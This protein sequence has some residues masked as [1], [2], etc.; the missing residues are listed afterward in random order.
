MSTPGEVPTCLC[1]RCG[2]CAAETKAPYVAVK[3][4]CLSI[5]EDTLLC[6]LGPNGAGKTTT[7]HML[8]GF[9]ESTSGDATVF[10][11]SVT[12]NISEIQGIMGVCPQ[13]DILVRNAM[14]Q[15]SVQCADESSFV[16][17]SGMN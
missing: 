15:F 11:H 3:E 5:E 6:L 4:L 1:C 10:G 8:V 7:I 14:N 17:I 13:F 16:M 2:P 12:Q 9:H